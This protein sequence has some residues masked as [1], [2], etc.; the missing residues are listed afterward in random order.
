VVPYDCSRGLHC[1][2]AAEEQTE[3]VGLSG[4]GTKRTNSIARSYVGY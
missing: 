4:V 2:C 1:S 3:F